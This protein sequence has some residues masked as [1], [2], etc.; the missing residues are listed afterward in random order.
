M[1]ENSK[2]LHFLIKNDLLPE[3][4]HAVDKNLLKNN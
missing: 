1:G 2:I 4:D 3:L